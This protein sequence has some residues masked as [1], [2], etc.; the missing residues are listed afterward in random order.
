MNH[1][2]VL[3]LIRQAKGKPRDDLL[4]TGLGLHLDDNEG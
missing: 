3:H 1:C 2:M 4:S